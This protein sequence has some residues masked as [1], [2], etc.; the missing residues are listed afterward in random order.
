[1]IAAGLQGLRH[2]TSWRDKA[3]AYY[4]KRD[5]LDELLSRLQFQLPLCPSADNIAA[6]AAGHDTVRKDI[7][8]RLFEANAGE[9]QRLKGDKH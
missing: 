4:A 6:I 7:G 9:D 1:M 5:M 3:S 8:K 2:K